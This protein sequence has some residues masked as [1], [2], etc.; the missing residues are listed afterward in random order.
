MERKMFVDAINIHDG[1]QQIVDAVEG[2]ARFELTPGHIVDVN[3]F[4][5][6]I[7]SKVQFWCAEGFYYKT[8]RC[9]SIAI[10]FAFEMPTTIRQQSV[11]DYI[12]EFTRN[13]KPF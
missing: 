6:V 11:N 1:M 7:P 13:I 10:P 12:D 2:L 9:T 5:S 4:K 3:G 8:R